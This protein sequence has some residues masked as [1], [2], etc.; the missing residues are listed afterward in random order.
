PDEIQ[1][2]FRLDTRV[3]KPGTAGEKGSGLGLVLTAELIQR[4]GGTIRT[5]SRPGDG[6]TMFVEVPDLGFSDQ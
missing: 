5:E 2:L 6:T 4:M 1:R 3:H